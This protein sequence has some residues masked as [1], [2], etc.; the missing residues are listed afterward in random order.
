MSRL[1]TDDGLMTWEVYASGGD[2][3]LPGRPKVIFQCLS[4]PDSRARYVIHEGDEADAEEA[5]HEASI[6][7]LRELLARSAELD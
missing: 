6:E 4:Q 5:V 7:R 3:G 2:F 1:F